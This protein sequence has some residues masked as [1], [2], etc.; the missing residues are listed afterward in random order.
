MNL[1]DLIRHIKTTSSKWVKVTFESNKD[2]GW[3][4]GYGAF[5]VGLST[6]ESVKSYIQN[7]EEHHAQQSFDKEFVGFLNAHSIR[8]DPRFVME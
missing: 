6:L 5:S 1:S 4:D 7:Q 8:Y 3:Q 2:F